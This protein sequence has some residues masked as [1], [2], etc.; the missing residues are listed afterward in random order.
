MRIDDDDD[1][2]EEVEQ[3]LRALDIACTSRDAASAQSLA[4]AVS[5]LRH[6]RHGLAERVSPASSLH[7]D[8]E[9]HSAG[10]LCANR[11][12]ERKAV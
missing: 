11:Q 9:S 10:G 12:S 1:L 4:L 3:A 2:A 8:H 5:E 7:D 6:A